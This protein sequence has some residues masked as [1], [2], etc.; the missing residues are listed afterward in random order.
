MLIVMVV[1]FYTARITLRLLGLDDYGVQNAVGGLVSFM[2]VI[3]GTMTSATQRFLSYA[4]G[5][6][7]IKLYSR[8][9]GGLL[10]ICAALSLLVILVAE[11][12]GPWIINSYLVIP[13]TRIY[14]AQW[15]YQCAI[16]TFVCS[17]MLIPF[18]AAIVS[19]EMMKIYAYMSLY[20][21]FAKLIIVTILFYSTFDKLIT[22]S[23]MHAIVDVS[24]LL[25]Y[26]VYCKRHIVG[27][28]IKFYYNKSL[29]KTLLSYTGWNLFGSL[30]G[31]LNVAG[32]SLVI[33]LFFGPVVNGAKA[34]ADRINSTVVSFSNNFYLAV[35]PQIVKKYAAG[36]KMM[37]L[38]LVY[39]SSKYSFFLLYLLSLPLLFLMRQCL[40]IW[41][42][43]DY[44]TDEMVLFSQL[45][46]VYSLV[47]VLEQP[48]S[49]IIRA[50]GDIK[51]Y[52]ICV[53]CITL[54]S[55]PLAYLFSKLSFPSFYC[56]LSLIITYFFAHIVR[57][58]ISMKQVAL[59]ISTYFKT[60]VLPILTVLCLSLIINGVINVL[61][62][63]DDNLILNI[64]HG[65]VIV[66]TT[67]SV[68][69]WIGFTSN[70]RR[71]I[72][73]MIALHIKK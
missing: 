46:L 42:G 24:I 69:Y 55:V 73:N 35:S 26:V 64:I 10:F 9:F 5:I 45:I 19:H 39:K 58:Y 18:S 66:L 52:Q 31:T 33:N 7:D 40:D 21:V 32:L 61:F 11:S 36:E 4:L 60:V 53:G 68:I 34:I 22:L 41:L 20:E 2:N 1:T 71:E 29:I 12:I 43:K 17:L 50:T 15:V 62:N 16:V 25:I 37:S 54:M 51:W 63:L 65:L 56:I 13:P 38:Q 48:I 14:A 27:C 6:K 72:K 67:G 57:L 23:V 3:R 47:N 28:V 8:N 70:E 59:S 49:M 30:S 44:V